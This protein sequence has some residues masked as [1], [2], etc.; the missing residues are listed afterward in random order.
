MSLARELTKGHLTASPNKTK[1]R[2][3]ERHRSRRGFRAQCLFWRMAVKQLWH[4]AVLE[5]KCIKG[6]TGLYWCCKS[7]LLKSGQLMLWY[8]AFHSE[9]SP[10]TFEVVTCRAAT[11]LYVK[12]HTDHV[13]DSLDA[14]CHFFLCIYKFFDSLFTSLFF[15]VTHISYL[16]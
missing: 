7:I 4:I 10:Y 14:Q 2:G 3:L 1:L 8:Q 13:I 5:F 15:E 6:E 9:H 16:C 11:Y 12:Y